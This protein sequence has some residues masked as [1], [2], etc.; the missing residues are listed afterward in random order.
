MN[1]NVRLALGILGAVLI[2]WPACFMF[3]YFYMIIWK[4]PFTP[5]MPLLWAA[6]ISLIVGQLLMSL[7]QRKQQ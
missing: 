3:Y 4:I 6:L 1:R 5:N 7:I 2:M